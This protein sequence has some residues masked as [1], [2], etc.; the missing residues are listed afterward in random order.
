[1][2]QN[3]KEQQNKSNFLAGVDLHNLNFIKTNDL[4][5]KRRSAAGTIIT[6]GLVKDRVHILQIFYKRS[7]RLARQGF[8]RFKLDPRYSVYFKLRQHLIDNFRAGL[9]AKIAQNNC[10][11]S[12]EPLQVP[13]DVVVSGFPPTSSLIHEGAQVE[14]RYE[15]THVYRPII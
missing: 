4:R 9:L 3:Y 12:L 11:V 6:T 8:I 7:V 10:F 14:S 13:N 1:M 15:V 5:K 2:V